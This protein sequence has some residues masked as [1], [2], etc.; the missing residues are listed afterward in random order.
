MD[1]LLYLSRQIDRVTAFIGRSVRWLILATVIVSTVNAV[2]R[3]LFDT[4]SNAWLELQWYLFGAVFMLAASY[5]LQTNGH[6]R[7]DVLSSRWSKRHRDWIDLICHL[8]MLLP[9][10]AM[11]TWLSLPYAWEAIRD[12]ELSSN[13][14][15]LPLWPPKLFIFL[16]FLLLTFQVFSEIVKRIAVIR[17]LIP[18]PYSS[19][20]HQ[21]PTEEPGLKGQGHD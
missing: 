18:E 9:F 1:V 7:I 13:A 11:M 8:V 17:D 14:G 10:A 15:G 2:V 4:S 20:G 12:G 16:G 3:K 21:Q 19:E 5:V 6:I